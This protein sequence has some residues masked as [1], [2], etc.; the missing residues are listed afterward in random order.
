M[1]LSAL[2]TR[3]GWQVLVAVPGPRP[4]AVVA[5]RE[6]SLKA[7]SPDQTELTVRTTP[8]GARASARASRLV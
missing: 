1:D 7:Q 2:R 3:V 5:P 4:A 8:P 6:P